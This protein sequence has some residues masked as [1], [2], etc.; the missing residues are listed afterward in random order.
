MNDF[1]TGPC[2]KKADSFSIVVDKV[3]RE[4][5]AG[6]Q[7]MLLPPEESERKRLI[8]ATMPPGLFGLL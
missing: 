8:A 2:I 4:R 5:R 7:R 1:G 3:R 6:L